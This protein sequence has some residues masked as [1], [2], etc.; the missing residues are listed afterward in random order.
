MPHLNTVNTAYLIQE[1][2]IQI[3]QM[4]NEITQLEFGVK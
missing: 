1:L 2:M 4:A 3:D